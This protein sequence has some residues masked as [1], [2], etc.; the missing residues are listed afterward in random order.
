MRVA[1]H[2]ECEAMLSDNGDKWTRKLLPRQHRS[3]PEC[4]QSI[5]GVATQ[6]VTKYLFPSRRCRV[7]FVSPT[8]ATLINALRR[9]ESSAKFSSVLLLR[10]WVL[11]IVLTFFFWSLSVIMRLSCTDCATEYVGQFLEQL[12]VD[13]EHQPPSPWRVFTSKVPRQGGV[14]ALTSQ[15]LAPGTVVFA[16]AQSVSVR[17]TLPRDGLPAVFCAHDLAEL[18]FRNEAFFYSRETIDMLR[19]AGKRG[20]H[21]SA[22]D[23]LVLANGQHA[24]VAVYGDKPYNVLQVLDAA[25]E[26]TRGAYHDVLALSVLG[27]GSM[28]LAVPNP[29]R[30]VNSSYE[31]ERMRTSLWLAVRR[32][33]RK[34]EARVPQLSSTGRN[35]H[36]FFP[37][38]RPISRILE[39]PV[40]QSAAAWG[41]RTDGRIKT[42]L[43]ITMESNAIP[44]DL[45]PIAFTR[46]SGFERFVSGLEPLIWGRLR[47]RPSDDAAVAVLCLGSGILPAWTVSAGQDDQLAA[48]GV[49]TSDGFEIRAIPDQISIKPADSLHSATQRAGTLK[50]VFEIL[51]AAR[52]DTH[53]LVV[54]RFGEKELRLEY[55]HC[56]PGCA[57]V[58]RRNDHVV[59]LPAM[60]HQPPGVTLCMPI[61]WSDLDALGRRSMKNRIDAGFSPPFGVHGE[62]FSMP[63]DEQRR[64]KNL[65]P[66]GLPYSME[67]DIGGE[68]NHR[69]QNTLY[70]AEYTPPALPLWLN[71]ALD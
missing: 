65:L 59:N 49:S 39:G 38:G 9:R 71:H 64:V 55:K 25:F 29:T 63:D 68:R 13:E 70:A 26:E 31:L 14:C 12:D 2:L 47:N 66:P 58:H 15:S 48:I 24:E 11:F 42:L 33:P 52:V 18:R 23:P 20:G 22:F 67:V 35:D 3:R 1:E 45:P 56:P 60:M 46:Q 16:P 36:A 51:S 8:E 32:L 37:R 61:C 27:S 57:F 4:A 19:F 41:L 69:A 62:S 17:G 43:G 40:V 6:K 10:D 28:E 50:R 5:L 53:A 34:K 54:L 30:M 7:L 21:D 44:M